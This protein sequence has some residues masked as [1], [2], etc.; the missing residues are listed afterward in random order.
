MTAYSTADLMEKVSQQLDALDFPLARQFCER[1]LDMDS[2]NP[3]IIETLGSIYIELGMLDE[4][5]IQFS[6]LISIAPSACCYLYMGQLSSGMDSVGY[7]SKALE[8]MQAELSASGLSEAQLVDLK[9]RSSSAH[10]SL[11]EL[12]MTD[13]CYEVDAE[14]KCSYHANAALELDPS[15]AEA[16]Q[17]LA[18]L[19]VTQ[20]QMAEARRHA[21]KC[22]ELWIPADLMMQSSSFNSPTMELSKS[23]S[24]TS[25]VIPSYSSR[26]S[27]GKLL[28]ELEEYSLALIIFEMLVVEDD[29]DLEVCYLQGLAY[30]FLGS[31]DYAKTKSFSDMAMEELQNL[32][33]D[34]INEC[35]AKGDILEIAESVE[36]LWMR[37]YECLMEAR[38]IIQKYGCGPW[39]ESAG[40]DFEQVVRDLY[41]TYACVFP[42]VEMQT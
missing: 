37:G 12:F 29:E 3:A 26:C 6:N 24:D 41:G 33:K 15:N 32:L 11:A 10:C 8:Y 7:Y 2:R 34:S 30:W 38:K 5:R 23:A 9:S 19:L 35:A 28:L 16:Y 14:S 22:C 20:N 39:L 42:D 40:E 31:L 18:Q 25:K 27:L 4:A 13:C 36:T 21:I 17:T 1:A